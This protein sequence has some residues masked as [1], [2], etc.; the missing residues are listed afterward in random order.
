MITSREAERERE[1]ER[2]RDLRAV[3]PLEERPTSNL[4]DCN[5]IVAHGKRMANMVLQAHELSYAASL[6]E[7]NGRI[8]AHGAF[9]V[10][11]T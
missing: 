5:T 11:N 8:I 6:A 7:D 1:R 9:K 3:G 10:D 2:E 4:V